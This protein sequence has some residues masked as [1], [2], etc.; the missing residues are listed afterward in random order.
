[1]PV[2]VRDQASMKKLLN[3]LDDNN[4]A[5]RENAQK[6]LLTL[7][8]DA[9]PLL[10]HALISPT[11]TL[12]KKRRLEAIVKS[13]QPLEKVGPDQKRAMWG[14]ELLEQFNTKTSRDLLAL[15]G[16]G[17]PTAWL[18]T[19]AQASLKRLN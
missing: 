1:M 16:Q 5:V 13:L 14:I 9:L 19:E 3:D 12:E 15:I 2:P 10:S 4:F 17:E 6:K 7:G 18:T 11:N 8:I